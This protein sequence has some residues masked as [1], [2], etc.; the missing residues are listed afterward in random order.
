MGPKLTEV[1]GAHNDG[2]H[3]EGN[4]IQPDRGLGRGLVSIRILLSDQ[5]RIQECTGG[6]GI[7]SKA[8]DVDGGKVKGEAMS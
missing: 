6:D 8:Q 4:I 3:R 7:A 5:G 1:E 2:M